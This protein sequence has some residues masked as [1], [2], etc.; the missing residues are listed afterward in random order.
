MA[1]A[2]NNGGNDEFSDYETEELDIYDQITIRKNIDGKRSAR[3]KPNRNRNIH[4]SST[5]GDKKLLLANEQKSTAAIA[6]TPIK[7]STIKDAIEKAKLR[8]NKAPVAHIR[9]P[10]PSGLSA[11]S[12]L[13]EESEESNGKVMLLS[14]RVEQ[15]NLK[16]QQLKSRNDFLP[17]DTK[18][19]VSKELSAKERDICD[20]LLG[21][22][23]NFVI[24][25]LFEL[26]DIDFSQSVLHLFRLFLYAV[27]FHQEQYFDATYKGKFMTILR[28]LITV[29]DHVNSQFNQKFIREN[30]KLSIDNASGVELGREKASRTVKSISIPPIIYKR[31]G[32]SPP[33]SLSG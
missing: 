30:Y 2:D 16:L 3:S 33:P 31:L 28:Q 14:E 26:Q 24:Y 21:N 22:F 11:D 25:R 8:L 17:E 1:K 32:I 6:A 5:T 9:F 7:K 4:G 18:D 15:M 12:N 10:S 13:Y 19:E 27:K 23:E 29:N 20:V